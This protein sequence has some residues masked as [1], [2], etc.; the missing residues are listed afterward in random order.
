DEVIA[1]IRRSRAVDDA[2]Q[3]LM[4]NFG[5]SE[6]QSQAILDM[7]LQRLTGMERDKIEAERK[8]LEERIAGLN[9]LLANENLIRG[10]IRKE[11]LEYKTKFGD[12]RRTQIV[13]PAPEF[14]KEDTISE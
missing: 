8:E 6:L 5:L 1:L 3:G 7:R 9:K 13:G 4:Q 11:L 12:E 10:V 14:R 2:R